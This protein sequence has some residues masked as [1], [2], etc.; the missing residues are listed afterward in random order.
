MT[1]LFAFTET[2]CELS[3]CLKD[4]SVVE[5]QSATFHLI[6]TKPRNVVWI[7]ESNPVTDNK[8]FQMTVSEGGMEHFLTI[9]AT[10]LEDG[11][12][13]TAQIND[14][15]YGLKSSSCKL[16]VKGT[17]QMDF[18]MNTEIYCLIRLYFFY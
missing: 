15:Q 11:G 12:E 7:K 17:K 10:S 8:H 18:L 14:N 3:L 9:S 5:G 6:L 13:F 1:A 2:P 16:S 4:A